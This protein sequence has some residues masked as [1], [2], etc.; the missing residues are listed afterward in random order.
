MFDKLA[1]ILKIKKE[2]MTI[3]VIGLNG[4]GKSTIINHFKS[5]NEQTT[6]TVPTVGFTIEQFQNQG[7]HFTIIDTSGARRHRNLWE[8]H[9]KN[10]QGI[11]YVIDSSDK[12]RMIVIRDEI[13]LFLN[14][15]HLENRKIPILLFAN[16]QN[17]EDAMS[18]SKIA[19]VLGLN[20]INNNP[21]YI[22][23]SEAIS[24][25]GLEE[26]I[27]WLAEQIR[28]SVQSSKHSK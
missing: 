8:H 12:M 19:T 27:Q 6:I 14:H 10:C 28:L 22:S 9:F 2:K 18:S 5:L 23:S 17:S 11:V 25:V 21:W 24:G 7:V 1:N 20:E 3:L 13:N 4:G 15:P 26:G 16:K